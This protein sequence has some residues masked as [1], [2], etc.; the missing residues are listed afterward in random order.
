[1]SCQKSWCGSDFV[2][3]TLS[4]CFIQTI[5]PVITCLKTSLICPFK[6]E[7][8]Y[9]HIY[10]LP[11]TRQGTQLTC[12]KGKFSGQMNLAHCSSRS[13][14]NI[15]PCCGN[16]FQKIWIEF[17]TSHKAL[18]I[19]KKLIMFILF[20]VKCRN[21]HRIYLVLFVIGVYVFSMM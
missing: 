5:D 21:A 2:Q 20:V 11:Q 1:M 3:K 14:C 8:G 7:L 15:S 16:T 13:P 18:C 6:A 9:K 10:S 19:Y 17:Y 4:P 12:E